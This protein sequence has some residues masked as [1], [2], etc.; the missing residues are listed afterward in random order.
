[1][2]NYFIL[3]I[4][5]E[6]CWA[7]QLNL[8][9]KLDGFAIYLGCI[10]RL[11]WCYRELIV[12]EMDSLDHEVIKLIH[13]HNIDILQPCDLFVVGYEGYEILVCK[14]SHNFLKF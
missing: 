11:T 12:W 4:F 9:V 14:T 8:T 5:E 2:G 3:A 10:D 7:P 6:I 1:M 13:T